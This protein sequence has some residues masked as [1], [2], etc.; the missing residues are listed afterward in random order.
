[1]RVAVAPEHGDDQWSSFGQ[2]LRIAR[3]GAG[4]TQEELSERCGLSVRAI[5]Y[6]ETERTRR[7]FMKTVRLLAAALNLHGERYEQ[8][9][10]AAQRAGV[11]A[12]DTVAAAGVPRQ[13]PAC[14]PCFVGRDAEMAALSAVLGEHRHHGSAA[15]SAIIGTAGVGKTALAVHWAHRM[16]RH[17]PGGQLYVNLRGFG[18]AGTPLTPSDSIR[19]LLDALD[20]PAERIPVTLDAQIGRTRQPGGRAE[21]MVRGSSCRA[22]ARHRGSGDPR[23]C[24]PHPQALAGTRPGV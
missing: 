2:L 14:L 1:M 21:C 7:P 22:T 19:I 3:H 10:Q 8:L 15:V 11:D 17:F 6:L 24:D 23:S 12:A 4:L 13:L 9:C 5:S 20:E 18:P 16:I